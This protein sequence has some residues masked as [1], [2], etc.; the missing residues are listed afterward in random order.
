MRQ[1]RGRVSDLVVQGGD[2]LLIG[3]GQQEA[4]HLAL[5]GVLHLHVDVVAR[6][7]LLVVGV[8]AEGGGGLK[9]PS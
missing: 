2:L 7:L 9:K 6:R 3:C 1:Q 4:A 5:Q 8:D